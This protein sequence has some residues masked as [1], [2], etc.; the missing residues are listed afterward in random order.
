MTTQITKPLPD[1]DQV[2][3]CRSSDQT[4]ENCLPPKSALPIKLGA[5][6]ALFVAGSF[7]F[8]YIHDTPAKTDMSISPG[9]PEDIETLTG[10]AA[11][12]AP[13]LGYGNAVLLTQSSP[14]FSAYAKG[15]FDKIKANLSAKESGP[16]TPTQTSR[17]TQPKP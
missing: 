4:L 5:A 1:C 9:K 7:T 10:Y 12:T 16:A 8:A 13:A 3:F 11:N 15:R 6:C 17:R 2:I 14:M